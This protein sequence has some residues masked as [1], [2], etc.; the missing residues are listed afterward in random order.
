MKSDKKIKRGRT[1]RTHSDPIQTNM[2]ESK[3]SALT[4]PHIITL[5]NQV[6]I[7]CVNNKN[8]MCT[9]CPTHNLDI[10]SSIF[11]PFSAE[12]IWNVTS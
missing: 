6:H 10:I 12:V 8:S 9:E 3:H 4:F 5:L 7:E 2:S 11:V 1:S